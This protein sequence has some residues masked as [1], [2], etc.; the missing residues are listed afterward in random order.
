M[1]I[2][3][4]GG[5]GSGKS[6]VAKVFERLGALVIDTDLLA[7]DA[8][9]AHTDG[10]HE[11]ARVW[12]QVL[13]NGALD[14]AKLAE[15]VFADP[16][17]RERLNGIVHPH[18]RRLADRMERSAKPG[19]PIVQMIPLLFESR[20]EAT[21]DKTVVV[22]APDEKRVARTVKRDKITE[23]AVRSR[24]AAQID[25]RLARKRA[26]YVILNDGDLARLQ[27]RAKAT[28]EMLV[29]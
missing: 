17:A 9:A 16:V 25:P 23:G 14:R 4:T 19:Q 18:V 13:R 1:R 22:I 15:I 11:I 3:L 20:L 10:L 2:G 24:M 21:M 26:D 28:Y 27:E 8:V 12:P 29:S 5:I 6:E 7:R